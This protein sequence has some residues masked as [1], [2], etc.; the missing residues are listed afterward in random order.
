MRIADHAN[1][2]WE[3]EP[4]SPISHDPFAAARIRPRIPLDAGFYGV[5]KKIAEDRTNGLTTTV[6]GILVNSDQSSL[7]RGKTKDN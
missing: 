1:F 2:G 6:G 3:L 5:R 4:V 7:K